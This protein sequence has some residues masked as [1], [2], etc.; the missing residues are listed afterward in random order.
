MNFYGGINER[1]Y[2]LRGD[3]SYNTQGLHYY[4]VSDTLGLE[5]DSIAQRYSDFGIKAMFKSIK[6]DSANLNYQIGFS[7]NNYLSK[8]PETKK[9][10]TGGHVKTFWA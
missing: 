4:G 3:V 5:R 8:A 6:K 2:V 7:Y 10:E 9:I 1:R